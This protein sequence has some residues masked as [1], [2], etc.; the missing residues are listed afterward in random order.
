[1]ANE[2]VPDQRGGT[3]DKRGGPADDPLPECFQDRADLGLEHRVEDDPSYD[4]EDDQQELDQAAD[5][6][7]ETMFP[8]LLS[9]GDMRSTSLNLTWY[10][11]KSSR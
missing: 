1:M 9:T 8:I 5:D 6:L 11:F 7:H 10:C 4:D 2:G 3:P